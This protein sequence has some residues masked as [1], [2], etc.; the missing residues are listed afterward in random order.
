MWVTY[1]G[2]VYD[3]SAFV[4][5]HPGGALIMQAAGGDVEAFWAVWAYHHDAPKVGEFLKQLRIG[6][7]QPGPSSRSEHDDPYEAEPIRDRTAQRTLTERPFCS[8]TRNATLGSS[9]LTPAAALYVRNH[10]PVPDCAWPPEGESRAS[11]AQQHEVVFEASVAGNGDDNGD[12]NGDDDDDGDA[13]AYTVAQL[14]KRFGT[15]TVTAILQ[16]AGNRASEDIAATGASGFSGTPFEKITQ[17]MLGNAQW[18]GVRLADVLPTLYPD[19]CAAVRRHGGGEWHVVFEGADG[20][21]ASSPLARVLT[22]RND[23]LLA[24]HMNGEPLSPDH[25]YPCRALLAGVAGA[26][27]VKWLQ[28]VSLQ[29]RPIDAPWN[30]Y[31]YKNAKAQHIQALPLQSLILDT[32]HTAG[33]AAR[34]VGVSGV[35]YGGGSGNA[36]AR[37]EVSTDG[38]AS[39]SDAVIKTEEVVADGSLG[40]FGWVR[41]S[42]ELVA[43]N[44]TTTTSVCCRATDVE[45]NTQREVSA[46]ERG[47]CFSGWHFV[48]VEV[49]KYH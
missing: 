1:L 10:A 27:N 38:G 6:S 5:V 49:K 8:E 11:H 28:S 2:G 13:P 44:K 3:V 41:W 43:T 24:T 23:C 47:Y 21:A 4:H 30:E 25:G 40:N 12:G 22:R 9:Y 35:A 46:K 15:T 26:R 18:T 20:Y 7:L 17:G 37:V 39:W 29:R 33:T 34:R 14:E 42:A 32:T 16:C 48:E 31:Y 45:G 19:E 36:I